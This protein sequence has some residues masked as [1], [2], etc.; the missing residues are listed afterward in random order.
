[1]RLL[2]DLWHLPGAER[3]VLLLDGAAVQ[4]VV[5]IDVEGNAARRQPDVLGEPKVELTT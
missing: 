3:V 1:M 2:D 5:E 4:C